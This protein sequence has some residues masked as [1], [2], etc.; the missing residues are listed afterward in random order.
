MAGKE[1]QECETVICNQDGELLYANPDGHGKTVAAVDGKDITKLHIFVFKY[2][3][4]G[5]EIEKSRLSNENGAID[6]N[7]AGEKAVITAEVPVT[8]K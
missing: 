7:K 6:L 4:D 1:Y 5:L 3:E 8:G 2:M